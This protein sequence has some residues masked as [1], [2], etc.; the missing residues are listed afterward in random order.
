MYFCVINLALFVML[1]K[2]KNRD[3]KF[4]FSTLEDLLDQHHPLFKLANK[5]DWQSLE[6][7]FKV[8]YSKAKGR[9]S[10]SIRLMCGL[11]ILKHLRNISDESVVEQWSENAYYQYFCGAVVFTPKYPCNSTELVHFRKRI[12]EDGIELILKESI[13]VCKEENEDDHKK[14]NNNTTFID[15]TVQEKNITFPTDAKLHKK[16]IKKCLKIEKEESLPIRQTY[17]RT[18]KHLFRDQRFRNHPKNRKKALRAD[19][20]LKTIAGRLVREL[21]RNV[22]SES[23]YKELIELFKMVL[24]QTRKSKNKIYSL[25]EPE[26]ECISKGKEHKKYEF[27]NKV[28]IIRTASGLII[29]AKSFRKEYDGHTI[30]P[31]L[32]QVKKLTGEYPNFLAGDRGYRGLKQYK[33]TKI[34]IP[35]VPLKRDSRYQKEKKH[36]LF[37]K[38][39]GIEPTIGHLKSDYRV[40]RNFYKGLVGD[41]INIMLAAA[42]Y[43]FKRAMNALWLYIILPLIRQFFKKKSDYSNNLAIG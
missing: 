3:Q 8:L 22:G 38:R 18:L 30:G 25:H 34:V 20:K 16:I 5:I 12:G 7:S 33:E 10:K 9:P 17:T 21:E 13:R 2:E 37:C 15:S 11:L 14:K 39:A 27:G 4:L 35:D 40:K 28:S 31:A 6:D 1:S 19:R 42:A 29:G 43:N 24:A 26:T 23:K 36:K 32:E 41:A